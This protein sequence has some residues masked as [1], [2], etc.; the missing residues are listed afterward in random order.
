VD[1]AHARMN[2]GKNIMISQRKARFFCKMSVFSIK[3]PISWALWELLVWGI[4]DA[5]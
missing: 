2:L 3:C 4:L 1:A 5:G